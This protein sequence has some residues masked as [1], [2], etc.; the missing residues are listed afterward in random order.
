MQ[1]LARTS[2]TRRHQRRHRAAIGTRIGAES[3]ADLFERRR[4]VRDQTQERR[5]DVGLVALLVRLEPPALVV[6]LEIPEKA[7]QTWPEV[8][9]RCRG[10]PRHLRSHLYIRSRY[11][12][13]ALA[14]SRRFFLPIMP[15]RGMKIL[16]TPFGVISSS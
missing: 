13:K 5:L 7:E 1:H 4:E 6:S 9:V 15:M 8:T 16:N 11:L 2:M 14:V 10:L 3:A 12:C